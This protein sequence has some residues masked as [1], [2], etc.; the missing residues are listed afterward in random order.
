MY[1][2]LLAKAGYKTK[3]T[4]VASTEIFQSSLERGEI[5]VVPE[6]VATYADFLNTAANG[7][8]APSVASPDLNKS[9]AALTPLAT[10]K[11]LSVLKPTQAVDQNAF[12]VSKE[13][14]EKH[15]LRTL[16]DLG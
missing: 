6:Y 4:N 1:A 8:D 7:K 12:A 16:S 15:N 9:L 13:F 10:A 11:G 2:D 3:V 14:A 5:D